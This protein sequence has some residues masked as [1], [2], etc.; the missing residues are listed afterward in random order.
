MPCVYKMA[1]LALVNKGNLYQGH[2]SKAF[3]PNNPVESDEE[4]G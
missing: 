1:F 3:K 2:A 4:P